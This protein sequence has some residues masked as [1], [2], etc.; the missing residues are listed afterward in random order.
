MTKAA[1]ELLD[2]ALE[3]SAP[4]R[5]E[6]AAKLLESLDEAQDDVAGAWADEIATRVSA[7]RAGELESTDWRTV[8]DAVEADIL[9]R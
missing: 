6:M 4:E 9:R 2:E 3:L 8:L 5:A 1:R 7:A